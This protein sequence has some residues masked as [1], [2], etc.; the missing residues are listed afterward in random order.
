MNL[1]IVT[2]VVVSSIIFA[3][4]IFAGDV[5]AK[6]NVVTSTVG[7]ASNFLVDTFQDLSADEWSTF[8][9]NDKDAVNLKYDLDSLIEIENL[10]TVPDIT[11]DEWNIFIRKNNDVEKTFDVA[12]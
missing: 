2:C 12:D 3:N 9:K 4:N 8:L 1:K 5:K 10:K 6:K 7:I 11:K